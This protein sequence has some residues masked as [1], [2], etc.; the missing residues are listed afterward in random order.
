MAKK[1]LSLPDDTEQ[2]AA[3][4]QRQVVSVLE[5][6]LRRKRRTETV[7]FADDPAEAIRLAEARDG[8]AKARD[9]LAEVEKRWKSDDS[10]IAQRLIAE[11]SDTVTE[12]EITVDQIIDGC[13]D[14]VWVF[15]FASIGGEAR[16]KLEAEYPATDEQI[17]EA[18]IQQELAARNRQ[19]VYALPHCDT[20]AIVLPIIAACMT[21]V[22]VDG[23]THPPLSLDALEAMQAPEAGGVWTVP[24]FN[25]MYRAALACDAVGSGFDMRSVGKG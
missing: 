1:T 25:M 4:E 11:A 3:V 14:N 15:E 13:G 7:T 21:S 2:A 24:D 22:T 10:T 8:L 23:E 18:K 19:T 9:A 20:E 6:A 12:A 16:R 5:R 17:D